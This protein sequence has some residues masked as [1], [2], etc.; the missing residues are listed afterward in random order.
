[1]NDNAPI[2]I[3]SELAKMSDNKVVQMGENSPEEVAYKLMRDIARA[4]RIYL[5]GSMGADVNSSREWILRTYCQCLQAVKT[6][7]QPDEVVGSYTPRR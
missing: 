7:Y 4:E 5:V 6:P 3:E 2:S 1:M